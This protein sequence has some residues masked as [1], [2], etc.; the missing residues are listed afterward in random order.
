MQI[1]SK[2]NRDLS[3]RKKAWKTFIGF[4]NLMKQ[5]LGWTPARCQSEWEHLQRQPD[6]DKD[7]TKDRI[8]GETIDW[9]L[10]D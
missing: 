10:V 2:V 5:E 4:S 8:T 3:G 1:D 6:V 9:L 7:V